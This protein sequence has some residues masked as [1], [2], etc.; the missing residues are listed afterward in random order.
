MLTF[1]SPLSK[2]MQIPGCVFHR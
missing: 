2:K 1:G